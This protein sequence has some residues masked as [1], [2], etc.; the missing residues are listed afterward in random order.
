MVESFLSQQLKNIETL[1]QELLVLTAESE[2]ARDDIERLIAIEEMRA[3]SLEKADLIFK[4]MT[5]QM[6][7]GEANNDP[8]Q[9]DEFLVQKERLIQLANQIHSIDQKKTAQIKKEQSEMD[10]ALHDL[11]LG[12]QAIS[13]YQRWQPPL[14]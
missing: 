7:S 12:R 10:R 11:H 14:R 6:T 1:Y 4:E 13:Q 3:K 9:E 5:S 2:E 8:I